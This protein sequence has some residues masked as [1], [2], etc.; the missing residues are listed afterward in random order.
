MEELVSR[1]SAEGDSIGGSVEVVAEGVPAGLGD[2]V[3]HKLDGVLAWAMLSIG[4]VKGVEF[5][6]GFEVA[7][8]QGS[9]ANDQISEQ[10]FLSNHAGGVLG[11]ISSGQ[12][13]VMRLAIKPTASISKPQSTI[14]VYGKARTIE[15]KG[16][17]DPCL[18]PRIGPVAEAMTALVLADALLQQ[19]AAEQMDDKGSLS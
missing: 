14:D 12:L 15:I 13:I 9:K 11:G 8:M 7:T 10:G 18:C 17:H 1:L 6:S 2:P 16:R 19:R 3:F 5:G 4:A